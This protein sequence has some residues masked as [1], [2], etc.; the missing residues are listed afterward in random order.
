MFGH[1][2]P[3]PGAGRPPL[4][5]D[6]AMVQINFKVPENLKLRAM[7]RAQHRDGK[8]LA[9]VMRRLLEEYVEGGTN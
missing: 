1:G 2:G 4:N 3:R 8:P 7:A 6:T 5:G 9:A